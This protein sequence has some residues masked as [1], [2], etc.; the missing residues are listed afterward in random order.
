MT[1]RTLEGIRH[2]IDRYRQPGPNFKTW[3][4]ITALPQFSGV[5]FAT[6]RAVY[7]GREPQTPDV[8]R[9]LGLPVTA[10]V[11][12]CENCG[13]PHVRKT[14]PNKAKTT[15]KPRRRATLRTERLLTWAVLA[16]LHGAN[17]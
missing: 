11:P 7:Y 4:A 2:E 1:Y 13:E 14:C 8:R 5:S 6:L 16:L 17:R 15:G 10:P 12:V 9:A 3:R